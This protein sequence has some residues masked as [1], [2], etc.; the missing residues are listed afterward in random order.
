[1][2]MFLIQKDNH[3]TKRGRS[4]RDAAPLTLYTLVCM[5]S[6]L[7]FDQSTTYSAFGVK[8]QEPNRDTKKERN[9]SR[10]KKH[11]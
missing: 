6:L 1:M 5:L 10:A 7:L 2:Y 3:N 8:S 11:H 9:L 4:K